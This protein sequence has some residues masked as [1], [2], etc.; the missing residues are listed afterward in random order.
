ME[1][2]GQIDWQ[3]IKKQ[4]G[5]MKLKIHRGL[6]RFDQ[7]YKIRHNSKRL[8]LLAALKTI[9]A[10]APGSVAQAQE[11]SSKQDKSQYNT[12]LLAMAHFA[13]LDAGAIWERLNT[14]ID[15]RQKDFAMS[16]SA[17]LAGNIEAVRDGK[18]RGRKAATLR[19]LFG[20]VN[21]RFYCSIGGLRTIE[22]LSKREGYMEY[23]FLLKCINNPHSCLSV[24]DGLSQY[25]GDNCKTTNIKKTLAEQQ[26]MN[27]NS[28]FIVLLNSTANSSSGKHFVIVTPEFAA[29]SVVYADNN[30]KLKVYGFNSE[31]ITDPETYFVGTRNCGHVYNLTE[32]GRDKLIELFYSGH[33]SLA[34][35]RQENELI[36]FEPVG[37]QEKPRSLPKSRSRN[38]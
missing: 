18:K 4:I 24:I 26:A 33:L 16:L 9:A 25:Y 19:D 37:K 31:V 3:K 11:F 6:H 32:M 29:D 28:V 22:E 30:P 15:G 38:R 17:D 35:Q 5:I 27:P 20:S 7:K 2:G 23:D 21:N 8:I 14:Y 36:H 34:P 12:E 1:K 10:L 13:N